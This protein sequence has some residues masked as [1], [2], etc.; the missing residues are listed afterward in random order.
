M[1]PPTADQLLGFA[2]IVIV[3]FVI[4]ALLIDGNSQRGD[5]LQRQCIAAGGNWVDGGCV[6][7]RGKP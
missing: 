5:D 1:K 6:V 4:V 2:T 3:V 7:A